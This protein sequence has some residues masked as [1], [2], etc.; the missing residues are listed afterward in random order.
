[1]ASSL[2]EVNT[3][4]LTFCNSKHTSSAFHIYLLQQQAH[5]ISFSHLLATYY[6]HVI[7]YSLLLNVA[8]STH[9]QLFLL[10]LSATE[11][12]CQQLFT[13]TC[14]I[15][16]SCHQLLTFFCC[17]SMH[18][19]STIHCQPLT[20]HCHIQSI[21]QSATQVNH[22]VNHSPPAVNQSIPQSTKHGQPHSQ[23]VIHLQ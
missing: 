19:S 5:N 7:S 4:T 9:Y 15:V 20:T 8:S 10:L 12:T 3:S 13:S 14:Y 2:P 23:P 17:K 1:M 21:T 16:W 6:Y 22:S 18:T 11:C